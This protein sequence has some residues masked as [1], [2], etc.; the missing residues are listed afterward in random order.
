M[1]IFSKI[2]KRVKAKDK[3]LANSI[4][5]KNIE[6]RQTD[7]QANFENYRVGLD[8]ASKNLNEAVNLVLKDKDVNIDKSFLLT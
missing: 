8:L 6:N 7:R 4:Q 2:F 3:E 1:S 5:A